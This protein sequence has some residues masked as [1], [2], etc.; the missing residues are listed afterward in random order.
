MHTLVHN[1]NGV[2][3]LCFPKALLMKQSISRVDTLII[4][5]RSFAL[6]LK[7]DCQFIWLFS[8]ITLPVF[9]EPVNENFPSTICDLPIST[10][11]PPL[12]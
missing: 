7:K 6:K 3:F 4:S 11:S 8:A 10:K 9:A 1:E 5:L 2:Y 12:Y